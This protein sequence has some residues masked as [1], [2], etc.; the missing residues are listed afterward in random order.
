VKCHVIFQLFGSVG[1]EISGIEVEFVGRVVGVCSES[2]KKLFKLIL[3]WRDVDASQLESIIVAGEG[4]W[5]GDRLV[6]NRQGPVPMSVTASSLIRTFT[7]I[8]RDF[9][10]NTTQRFHLDRDVFTITSQQCKPA[11]CRCPR[12]PFRGRFVTAQETA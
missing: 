3:I 10:H 6:E 4:E 8:T 2:V 7:I 12:Y 1:I 5:P 11:S 9:I